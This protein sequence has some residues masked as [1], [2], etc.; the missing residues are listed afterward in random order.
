[1]GSMLYGREIMQNETMPEIFAKGPYDDT[2]NKKHSG[3]A[4]CER[5][6]CDQ[7]NCEERSDHHFAKIN[8][9]HHARNHG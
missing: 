9:G 4:G 8:D 6:D 1:M 7:T 5:G 2:A 3:F